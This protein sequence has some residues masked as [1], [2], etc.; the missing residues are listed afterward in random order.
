ME[1]N[2]EKIIRGRFEFEEQT[3]IYTGIKINLF[4]DCFNFFLTD[5]LVYKQRFT[6]KIQLNP[7]P[8]EEKLI[9]LAIRLKHN[10]DTIEKLKKECEYYKNEISYLPI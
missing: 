10:E 8:I 1:T 4:Y 3:G 6:D 2:I 9:N 7:N 5:D